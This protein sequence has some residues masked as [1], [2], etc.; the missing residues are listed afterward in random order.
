MW[1]SHSL[2]GQEMSCNKINMSNA[3]KKVT[4]IGCAEQKRDTMLGIK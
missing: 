2:G 1:I 4:E 3:R